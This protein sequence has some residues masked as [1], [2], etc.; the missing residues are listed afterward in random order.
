M[1]RRRRPLFHKR[2]A[3][4]SPSRGSWRL[5]AFVVVGLAAATALGWP[6]RTEIADNR[7]ELCAMNR[8]PCALNA[9]LP[10]AGYDHT[11]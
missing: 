10:P 2:T 9:R 4:R 3:R 11:C 7:P 1:Q 5:D 6:Y 8:I